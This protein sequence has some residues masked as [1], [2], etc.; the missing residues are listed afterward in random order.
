MLEAGKSALLQKT[1]EYMGYIDTHKKNVI[2]AWGELKQALKGVSFLTRDSI[3][4]E[5]GYRARNHDHSKYSVGEFLAYR[6]RFYP[7]P[8]EDVSEAD[9]QKAWEMHYRTNDHHWQNWDVHNDTYYGMVDFTCQCLEM[10]CD[11]QAMGY[12]FGD[13]A[14]AYYEKNKGEMEMSDAR[15]NFVEEVLALLGEYL[16]GAE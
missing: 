5:M 8:G 3:L 10:I 14:I 13:N 4:D 15:R 7:V 12:V 11:W 2:L 1:G 9:F 6:Q 16:A